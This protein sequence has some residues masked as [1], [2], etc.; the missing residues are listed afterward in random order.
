MPPEES[1]PDP[2]HGPYPRKTLPVEGLCQNQFRRVPSQL[3]CA[4]FQSCRSDSM[5][6][7]S[8]SRPKR[9]SSTSNRNPLRPGGHELIVNALK[10]AFPEG[11]PVLSDQARPLG[12]DTIVLSFPTMESVSPRTSTS[13]HRIAGHAARESPRRPARRTIN[14]I[15]KGGTTFNVVFKEQK[16]KIKS[17]AYGPNDHLTEHRSPVSLQL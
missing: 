1:E 4:L 2:L 16:K 3:A 12:Q 15:R 13:K 11:R 9:F 7:I 6:P 14:L 5:R 17:P 8:T 10:Y